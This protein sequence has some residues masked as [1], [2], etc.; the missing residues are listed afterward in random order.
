MVLV[1]NQYTTVDQYIA[2]FPEDTRLILKKIRQIIREAAPDSVETISY[3]MPTY[4]LKGNLVHFAAH[5]KHIGFYPTPSAIEEFKTELN[6]Y[7]TSKGA[8]RF[9]LDQ[10]LPYDLIKRIVEYRVQETLEK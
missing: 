2:L 5:T 10:P 8:I 7:E 9:P 1:D 3:R 6:P 4:K